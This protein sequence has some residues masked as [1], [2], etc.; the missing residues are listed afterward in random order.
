MAAY[1]AH[2]A[3]MVGKLTAKVF[4][5]VPDGANNDAGTDAGSGADGAVGGGAGGDAERH[6]CGRRPVGQQLG[7]GG[8]RDDADGDA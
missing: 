7:P 4:R 3:G 8:A 2:V 5:M 1:F 6:W